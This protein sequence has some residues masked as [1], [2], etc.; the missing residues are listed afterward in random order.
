MALRQKS[1]TLRVANAT[2]PVTFS[3][4]LPSAPTAGQTVFFIGVLYGPTV[5]TSVTICG[6]VATL[7]KNVD[8]NSWL[9]LQVYRATVP[10]SGATRDVVINGSGTE[11]YITGGAAEFDA[12]VPSPLDA[13]GQGAGVYNLEIPVSTS[14]PTTQAV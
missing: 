9:R 14:A 11:R 2:L 1:A 12:L 3:N 5:P 6:G 8:I 13:S 4:A 10:S 7:D